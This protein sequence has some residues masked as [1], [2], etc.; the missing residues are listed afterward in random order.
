M[1][2]SSA[3]LPSWPY[4]GVVGQNYSDVWP[5]A[6]QRLLDELQASRGGFALIASDATVDDLVERLVV[7]IG[8]DVVSLGAA[9]AA[10]P[11]PPTSEDVESAC[12]SAT[13]ITDIDILMWPEVHVSPW[14][15]LTSLARRRPIIAVWPGEVHKGRATYSSPGRPDHVDIALR[16]VV[17]L[18]PRATRFPDEVPYTIERLQP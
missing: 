18:R 3:T 13:V 15:L 11:L 8:L 9:L 4:G 16:D 10:R 17:L 6:G 12:G 2:S 14:N 1:S 7:D 5:G